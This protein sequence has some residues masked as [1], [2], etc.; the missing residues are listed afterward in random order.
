L[1]NPP[2][3]RVKL[4]EKEFFASRDTAIA[5]A[6]NAAARRRLILALETE[7]PD[8]WVEFRLATRQAAG[9]SHLLRDSKIY[10]YVAVE[11]LTP[12]LFLQN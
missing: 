7:N 12:M 6:P 11:T 3:E 10:H 4:Q 2:W 1:G 9:V 8:L 5:N